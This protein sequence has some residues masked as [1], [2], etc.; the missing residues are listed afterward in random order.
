MFGAWLRTLD[1]EMRNTTRSI[2]NVRAGDE[3]FTDILLVQSLEK[4]ISFC[5]GYLRMSI[6][7]LN[8]H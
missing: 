7:L 3:E 4:S 8:T 5:S 2:F 6:Y 1:A